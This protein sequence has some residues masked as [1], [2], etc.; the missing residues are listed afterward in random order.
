MIQQLRRTKLFKSWARKSLLCNYPACVL[1]VIVPVF[2]SF[3]LFN[4]YDTSVFILK[5]F[6]EANQLAICKFLLI[7]VLTLA[8]LPCLYGFALWYF[9][10][11]NGKKQSI[12]I[13][14]E[15]YTKKAALKRAYCSFLVFFAA[16]VCG[17]GL[18]TLYYLLS[19]TESSCVHCFTAA[20]RVYS[21]HSFEA[22]ALILSFVPLIFVSL[23]SCYV[24]FIGFT[25]PYIMLSLGNLFSYIENI[26]SV[27]PVS[28]REK[29]AQ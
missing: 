19:H 3:G 9:T 29:T 13:I 2:I 16:L 25:I 12:G 8:F 1:S 10:L 24:L 5:L 17:R 27:Y 14:I 28:F 7:F 4:V 15:A 18:F 11:T 23:F 20:G 6:C 22:F 26:Y 21:K